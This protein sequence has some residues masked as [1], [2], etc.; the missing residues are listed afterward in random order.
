MQEGRAWRPPSAVPTDSAPRQHL[1]GRPS[2][3]S[4]GHRKTRP[5][6]STSTA[7]SY[8]HLPYHTRGLYQRQPR[9]QA[10]VGSTD[11]ASSPKP[12]SSSSRTWPTAGSMMS[13]YASSFDARWEFGTCLW[14]TLPKSTRSGSNAGLICGRLLNVLGFT[15]RNRWSGWTLETDSTHATT[16]Q[17]HDDTERTGV[18]KREKAHSGEWQCDRTG[19]NNKLF[20]SKKKCNSGS[21]RHSKPSRLS[22]GAQGSSEGTRACRIGRWKRPTKVSW[23]KTRRLWADWR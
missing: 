3:Q 14:S 6:T 13:P 5:S 10:Q 19:N 12:N 8:Q 11:K 21:T 20:R 7:Y 9:V 1:T 23:S 2:Q 17:K 18:D 22:T 15:S 4:A 16:S